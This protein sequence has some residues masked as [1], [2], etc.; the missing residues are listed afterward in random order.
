MILDILNSKKK[1]FAILIDPDKH[2]ELTLVQFAHKINSKIVDLILVG[3]SLVNADMDVAI[4]ILKKET[5]LPVVLFPG[6]VSQLTEKADACL[7][8]SLISGRNPE[9]L[10]GS[11]VKAAPFIK[12]TNLETIPTGYI[13]IDGGVV[14][15]VEY[16]SNTKPIPMEKTELIVATAISA[17]LL[18]MKCIYLEA[19]S[20]AKKSIE[21]DM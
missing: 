9:Y 12:R 20:G 21:P 6:D 18:G 17:E 15:S 8:L 7:F 3:G 10:I 11:H 16:V 13:L 14:S 1:K 2:S 19:G 5:S 4:E